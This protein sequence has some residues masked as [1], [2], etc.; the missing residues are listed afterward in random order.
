MNIYRSLGLVLCAGVV[1][2]SAP[3]ARAFSADAPFTVG[4]GSSTLFYIGTDGNVGIGTLTPKALLDLAGSL[5]IKGPR[6]WIDVTAYGAVGDGATD[7]TA[8][9]QAALNAV[10]DSGGTVYMPKGAYVTTGTLTIVHPTYLQGAG[11]GATKFWVK[12]ADG[13]VLVVSAGSVTI[14]Q[15]GFASAVPGGARH[16]GA[17]VH[18]MPTAG[19]VTLR[20]FSMYGG[21]VGVRMQA[22]TA[23]VENGTIF[24]PSSAAGGT[25]ILVDGGDDHFYDHLTMGGGEYGVPE[26]LMHIVGSSGSNNITNV[27]IGGAQNCLLVDPATGLAAFWVLSS[28]FDNCITHGIYIHTTGVG[29]VVR[30]RIADS[31][32]SSALSDGITIENGGVGQINGVEINN[33]HA[34]YNKGNGLSIKAGPSITNIK[35][36]GGFYSGNT[37]SGIAVGAGI[38]AF[39]VVDARAGNGGVDPTEQNGGAGVSVAAG[40][41]DNYVIA[42]NDLRGNAGGPIQDG[43]TGINKQVYGNLPSTG[44]SLFTVTGKVGIGTASPITKLTVAGADALSPQL[45]FRTTDPNWIGRLGQVAPGGTLGILLSTGGAWSVSGAG[46]FSATKD[47]NGSFPSAALFIGN[48]YN[49]ALSTSFRFLRKAGGVTTTDGAVTELMSIDDN[50]NVSVAGSLKAGSPQAPK[51]ITLYDTANGSP[52]C[53]K[54]TN[55]AMAAAAG[56]CQ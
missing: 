55:G 19:T 26:S 47:Y 13:D 54:V 43:G 45:S 40:G 44:D 20:Q 39:S 50:G 14:E 35:V 18:F 8:A 49:G 2:A 56:A 52:Y 28:Y 30:S 5:T 21:Y 46:V 34:F 33:H 1:V 51:G 37:G 24:A 12:S 48:Q 3:Q 15:V 27:D 36:E 42:S 9:I 23:W 32:T 41:S 53:L 31:W 29:S 10:P 17:Y 22:T 25:G 16:S 38:S 6:P 11:P 7:D 4:T